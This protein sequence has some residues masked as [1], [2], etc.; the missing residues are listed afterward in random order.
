VGRGLGRVENWGGAG[1]DKV[2]EW[3]WVKWVGSALEM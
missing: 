3:Y 1:K 2:E